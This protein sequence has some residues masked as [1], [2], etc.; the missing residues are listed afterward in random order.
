VALSATNAWAVG[1]FQQANRS[2]RT[3][4]EH[5]NGK[6]WKVVNSP[7]I[8]T[9]NNDLNALAF[10]AGTNQVWTVGEHFSSDTGTSASLT[11]FRC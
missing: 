4:T 8:G 1:Y 5:W 7:N 6:N 2:Q 3:L 10:I 11:L 9:D